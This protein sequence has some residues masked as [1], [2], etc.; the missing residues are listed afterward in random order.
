MQSLYSERECH[1]K[2]QVAARR[3]ATGPGPT[4]MLNG[5]AEEK[6]AD[7]LYKKSNETDVLNSLQKKNEIQ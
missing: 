6:A 3:A 5:G 4:I 2:K 7:D 1:E